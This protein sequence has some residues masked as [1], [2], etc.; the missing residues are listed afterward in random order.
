MCFQLN[1]TVNNSTDLLVC[2]SSLFSLQTWFPVCYF[3]DIWW[4]TG[5]Y[6][7][8]GHMVNWVLHV[9]THWLIVGLFVMK[10]REGILLMIIV[11]SYKF[12]LFEPYYYNRSKSLQIYFT[13]TCRCFHTGTPLIKPSALIAV[14]LR[15]SEVGPCHSGIER[16]LLR[17]VIGREPHLWRFPR[18]SAIF[19]GTVGLCH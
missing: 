15:S 5:S 10:A 18:A 1:L 8:L 17:K 6:I 7:C 16:P 9:Q 19:H 4:F 3:K 14:P 13:P 11:K 2:I 12:S